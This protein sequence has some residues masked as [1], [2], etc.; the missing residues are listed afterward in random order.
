MK[1]IEKLQFCNFVQMFVTTGEIPSYDNWTNAN[2]T[3]MMASVKDGPRNI[4]LKFGQTRA[5][6]S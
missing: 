6:N 5:C 1:T 2:V 3:L 4:A